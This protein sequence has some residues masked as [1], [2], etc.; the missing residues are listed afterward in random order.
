MLIFRDAIWGVPKLFAYLVISFM[1]ENNFYCYSKRLFYF[2]KAFNI[3]YLYIGVNKNSNTRYYVFEKS[4]RLDRIID[5]YN[6][7]KY[8]I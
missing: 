3:D 7:L 4:D 2:I 1:G 6:K 8:S 5:L